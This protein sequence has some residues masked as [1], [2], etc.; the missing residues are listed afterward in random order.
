MNAKQLLLP[1]V[2]SLATIVGCDNSDKK[3]PTEATPPKSQTPAVAQPTK[4]P[5][6]AAPATQK[7]AAP[8]TQPAT[9]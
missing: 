3:K 4:A 2:V 9:K 6:V 7:A 5:V 8:S 1:A